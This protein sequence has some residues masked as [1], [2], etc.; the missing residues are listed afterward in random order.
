MK[1]EKSNLEAEVKLIKSWKTSNSQNPAFSRAR[2]QNLSARE[3]KK[4]STKNNC[5]SP[6]CTTCIKSHRTQPMR[7]VSSSPTRWATAHPTSRHWWRSMWWLPRWPSLCSKIKSRLK[8]ARWSSWAWYRSQR[9][10]VSVCEN[11]QP[12]NYAILS[13][14]LSRTKSEWEAR[15]SMS[16]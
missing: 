16:W 4:T 9:F 15:E 14:P 13:W 1:S 5:Q 11:T 12:R 2:S 7:T 3:R 6:S 8:T 10:A